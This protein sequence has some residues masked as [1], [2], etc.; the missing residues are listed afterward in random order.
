MKTHNLK[1]QH[2][3]TNPITVLI[4][5]DH[6]VV[7]LGLRTLLSE[8]SRFKV[9]GE[10][11]SCREAL[12][13]TGRLNPHIVLMDLRL[14][15]GSGVEVCR[16]ILASNPETRVFFLTSYADETCI[17]AAVLAG[18]S[19]YMLKEVASEGLLQAIEFVA[20]GHTV[21]DRWGFDQ[22]QARTRRNETPYSKGIERELTPQQ[23]RILA[24][25]AE[26]KTNK[27]IAMELSL[28]DKT[29]RNYLVAVF[30]KLQ[31]HRRSQAAAIYSQQ[32]VPLS[33]SR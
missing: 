21:L 11:G 30:E 22:V 16:E 15:D 23:T 19:G 1:N 2:F 29:V 14:P 24:L 3:S 32:Q 8:S 10:V 33:V 25:V 9:I 5:E 31:I 13:E 17:N 18:A 4:V 20:Q 12:S 28:S 7:R 26:G 27:E 6:A